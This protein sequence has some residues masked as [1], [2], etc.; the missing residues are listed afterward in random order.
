MRE[1]PDAGAEHRGTLG[2]VDH[3]GLTL[4]VSASYLATILVYRRARLWVRRSAGFPPR[5]LARL[6]ARAALQPLV[7]E[8]PEL[9]ELIEPLEVGRLAEAR[10]SWKLLAASLRADRRPW[11]EALLALAEAQ[12]EPRFWPRYK[13]AARAR[14]LAR[15]ARRS[16]AEAAPSYL[17]ALASLGYLCD[18][19]NLERVL[20]TTGRARRAALRARPQEPL[21]HLAVSLRAATAGETAEALQALARALYHAR[22]DRFVASLVASRPRIEDLDPARAA[23]A[24][25]LLDSPPERLTAVRT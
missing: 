25:R 9:N 22:G 5:L 3:L 17:H 20:F 8:A 2:A 14:S 11:V 13:L 16:T 18:P 19:L 24:A 23:A 12:R 21:L 10:E 1:A 7:R 6:H 4:L 15:E